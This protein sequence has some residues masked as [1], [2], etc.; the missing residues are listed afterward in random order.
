VAQALVAAQSD[1]PAAAHLAAAVLLP[2]G[3]SAREASM[4]VRKPEVRKPEVRAEL[5]PPA[6]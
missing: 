1:A 4:E 3:R 6:V 2:V 5:R